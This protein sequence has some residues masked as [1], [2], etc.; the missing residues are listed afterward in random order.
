VIYNSVEHWKSEEKVEHSFGRFTALSHSLWFD[1][2]PKH[3]FI[4]T[5]GFFRGEH[6]HND[7]ES[8][9][10]ALGASNIT[11]LTQ[12]HTNI[13]LSVN[14]EEPSLPTVLK[15]KVGDGWHLT[16]ENNKASSLRVFVLFTADCLPLLIKIDNNILLLHA[17][18]RGLANGLI[19]EKVA[20][21]LSAELT[22]P[23]TKPHLRA[24]LIIGPAASVQ[25]YQVGQEVIDEIGSTAVFQE[26][27][28]SLYLDL[29]GT[30]AV[31]FQEVCKQYERNS[32]VYKSEICTISNSLWHSHR[33]SGSNRGTN[34]TFFVI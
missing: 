19:T 28:N 18:W 8:L 9:R 5:S 2:G 27:A 13:V 34:V 6:Q 4:G 23:S 30:A 31:Q 29:A 25:E 3:G 7:L 21:V 22:K 16:Y 32:V 15:A 20:A 26:R 11:F 14:T 33:R 1:K 10:I 12:Q 24:E 17:G